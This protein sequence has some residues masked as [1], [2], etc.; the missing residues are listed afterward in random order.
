MGSGKALTILEIAELVIR[1]TGSSL[2]PDV[3]GRYRPGDTRHC[4]ADISRLQE[5]TGFSPT[6]SVKE[7]LQELFDWAQSARADDHSDRALDELK[8]RGLM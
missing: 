2:K 5:R 8:Q 6:I 4:F 1:H 7:R 3:T